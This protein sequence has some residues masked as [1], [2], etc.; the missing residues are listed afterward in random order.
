[1]KSVKPLAF[2]KALTM[3]MRSYYPSPL[4]TISLLADE[5]GL[6]GCYFVGQKYF[7][8]G[9]RDQAIVEGD[10]IFL[11]DATA[12]L[13]AYFAGENPKAEDV[14]LAPQGMAFQQSVWQVLREI[15]Y[16]KTMTYGEIAQKIQC[17]S[18]QAV[19]GAVGKNPL[20][21]FVPCHRV[22]GSQGQLTGYAG[23]LERKRWL[24]S[25]EGVTF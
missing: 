13:D 3:L 21:V 14:V 5:H 11:A 4:G 9:Y 6:L 10:S 8:N 15:P 12:W 16:G 17:A 1:M 23:G 19:G 25:H 7:E 24:L 18:A 22:L 20:S 2:G